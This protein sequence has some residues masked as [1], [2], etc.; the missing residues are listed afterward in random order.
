VFDSLFAT[1]GRVAR[2]K[3]IP[4]FAN[5]YDWSKVELTAD[6][7]AR[8][9]T[10]IPNYDYMA[11]ATAL[12]NALLEFNEDILSSY[13][14]SDRRV[15]GDAELA[16]FVRAL[17]SPTSPLFLKGFPS[18]VSRISTLSQIITQAVFHTGVQHHALNSYAVQK[19]LFV[20]PQNPGK[21]R[22][23]CWPFLRKLLSSS[24]LFCFVAF[25]P[26]VK[27]AITD[28]ILLGNILTFGI[29]VTS[30]ATFFLGE[31]NLGY[32]FAP[33]LQT[34][35]RIDAAFYLPDDDG[36]IDAVNDLREALI[37]ISRNIQA[38]VAADTASGLVPPFD[39]LDPRNLPVGSTI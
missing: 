14:Y 22:K 6:L 36:T 31:I 7:T 4:Y 2:E 25:I 24:F 18:T 30:F 1:S 3:V 29:P 19:Y 35:Q 38:R 23:S 16:G 28:A 39:L 20:Y 12:R 26:P 5:Q 32:S 9:V 13:Y 21:I 10:K 27:G 37:T 33:A 17:S 8:G 34:N 15:A 11:D